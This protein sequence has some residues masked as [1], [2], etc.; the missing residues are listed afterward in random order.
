MDLDQLKACWSKNKQKLMHDVY[1]TK[2]DMETIIKKRTAKTTYGLSRTF[3]MGIVSQALTVII[4]VFC[5]IKYGQVTS[6]AVLIGTALIL[7]IL[8]LFY[9]VNNLTLL[10]NERPASM[11][12][13][14]A[15]MKKINFYKVRYNKWL[16]SYAVSFI[17]MIWSINMIIGDFNSIDSFNERYLLVY[18]ACF[19]L[20]Y[21]SN[22]YAHQRYL[23]EYEINLHDLGGDH[24]TDLEALNK[25]FRRFKLLLIVVLVVFMLFGL[26]LFLV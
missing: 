21:F 15:L 5:L 2:D 1:L 9:T 10:R 3:F 25:K 24:L 26:V 13:S 14:D 17:V 11:S 20:I 18:T 12:I 19:L 22:R 8:A 6:L 7:M 23:K 16:L 4:L